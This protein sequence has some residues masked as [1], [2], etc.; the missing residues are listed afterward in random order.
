[1][2]NVDLNELLARCVEIEKFALSSLSTPVTADAVPYFIHQQESFPYFVNRVDTFAG[3][4]DS[5]E[6]DHDTYTVII[7][8]I[9]GHITEGY[10]GEPETKL[11]TYFPAVKTAFNQNEGLI[12]TAYPADMTNLL[13]G[14]DK[15][16]VSG[17]VFRV[18]QD[19]GLQGV[20]QVGSEFVLTCLFSQEL[21][22]YNL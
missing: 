7:R 19:G 13:E 14:E 11:Y 4:Y 3:S 22:L 9:V 6:I 15:R 16:I 1:M 2:S 10:V 17:T 18:F 8:L 21:D 5:N 20:R 12:S